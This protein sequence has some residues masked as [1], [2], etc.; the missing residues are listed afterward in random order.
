M[1]REFTFDG[2]CRKMYSRGYVCFSSNTCKIENTLLGR[3][4]L[5]IYSSYKLRVKKCLCTHFFPPGIFRDNRHYIRDN[6]SFIIII[7]R[8]VGVACG[9]LRP[10]VEVKPDAIAA[11]RLYTIL[12]KGESGLVF[13]CATSV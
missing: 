2:T 13:G 8:R 11:R 1:P 5:F 4:V 6:V 7:N 3:N 9:R 10:Q 12:A